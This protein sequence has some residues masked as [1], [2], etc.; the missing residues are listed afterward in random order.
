[1]IQSDN[2]QTR[3]EAAK[4]IARGGVIGFRTDTF[5]GLGANP[6]SRE[7]VRKV[8]ALKGREDDKPI[9]IL[10]SD[11]EQLSRFIS[12]VSELFGLLARDHWP[13]PL[14]LVGP[15]CPE[16]PVELTAGTGTLGVRLP[17]DADVRAL[18]AACG[19]ALTATSANISGKPPACTAREVQD[20]FAERIDLIID[21]GQVT[22]SEP[23]TVVDLTGAEPRV[24][25]EGAVPIGSLEKLIRS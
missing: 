6:L 8:R 14:T 20:Y 25:R 21:G 15:A 4:V 16:L 10:I 11:F 7:A 12:A 2:E 19:G 9:L 1:M 3:N 18:V 5:Y 22:V 23:S 24:V 13:A 17:D